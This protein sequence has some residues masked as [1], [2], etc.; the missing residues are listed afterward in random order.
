MTSGDLNDGDIDTARCLIASESPARIVMAP[1]EGVV[2]AI[3]RTILAQF[4]GFDFFLTEFIRV[5]DHV[6][7]PQILE[8]YAP[9][10]SLALA[11]KS[12]DVT[13]IDDTGM[14]VPLLIQFLGSNPVLIAENS[15]QAAELGFRGIDLNFGCPAPTVNRHDGGATLLKTPERIFRIIA[16]VR[17]SVPRT[18]SVSAKVRLGFSDQSLKREIAQAVQEGG[19]QWMTV[20]ART[21]DEGYR[22]P[23][24][25]RAIREMATAAPGLPI[26]AN[27][28]VWTASDYMAML[29]ESGTR[30]A[31]LGRGVL[32]RPAL[33]KECRNSLEASSNQSQ[34]KASWDEVEMALQRFVALCHSAKGTSF[35]TARTKQWL[36]T[37]ARTYPEAV[38]MF[39]K[40]KVKDQILVKDVSS[41]DSAKPSAATSASI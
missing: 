16:A 7:R 34:L 18:H 25:W 28:E 9:E 21:R 5:T 31:M 4:G 1:M 39:E 23:A 29:R 33:A 24:H 22:P 11:T 14:K 8:R 37:L 15:A 38:V 30:H 2:D 17:K 36:K 10:L 20:H 12:R 27:G 35:A 40:L 41:F 13:V 3:T 32:S 19:A 26:V 6:H